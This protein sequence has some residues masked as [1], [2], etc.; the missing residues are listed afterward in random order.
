MFVRRG[1][2]ERA[3]AGESLAWYFMMGLRWLSLIL[4]PLLFIG[5]LRNF[6]WP[7]FHTQF[8]PS[9]LIMCGMNLGIE[10][11]HWLSRS[12]RMAYEAEADERIRTVQPLIHKA[13][14]QPRE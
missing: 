12:I 1:G 8:L 6:G 13:P 9:I 2:L 10:V 4:L 11:L 7:Y 5:L 14:D 3:Q